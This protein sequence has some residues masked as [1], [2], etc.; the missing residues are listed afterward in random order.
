MLNTSDS[1]VMEYDSQI[2]DSQIVES[3]LTTKKQWSK[4]AILF[5]IDQWQ[6]NSSKF[7]STTIRNEEVWKNIVKELEDAGF[8]GYSWKQ[9]QDKW[10]NLRKA[11]MKVKDN[12]GDK[13]SGAARVTC[14][15]YDELDEIFTKS[16]S[17]QPISTASSRNS[18]SLSDADTDSDIDKDLSKHHS[19]KKKTK[20]QRDA[21]TYLSIL[22]EDA[23]TRETVRE[24]RH[25]QTLNVLNRAIDTY[26]AQMQKL[27]DK[28]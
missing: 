27:I 15:F 7:A 21:F 4:D 20:L 23:D 25:Q 19:I 24:E 14:K 11:Y 26:E 12:K 2:I 10:K 18:K 16:P 6:K 28:L 17:V 9:A 3:K 5:L 22:R 1:E 13:S 8:V